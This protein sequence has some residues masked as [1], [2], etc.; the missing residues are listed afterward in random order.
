[1]LLYLIARKRLLLLMVAISTLVGLASAKLNTSSGLHVAVAAT[2]VLVDFPEPSIVERRAL[3][4]HVAGLQL[5][6]EMFGRLMVTT[7]VLESIGRRAGIPGDQIAGVARTTANVPIPLREPGSEVR[8]AQVRD[9]QLPYH[10]ELQSSP[11][12][13]ILSIYAQAPTTDEAKRLADASILG[14]DDYVRGLAR[15]EGFDEA[16]VVRLRQLGDAR[17]GV[18]NPRAT[19]VTGALTFMVAFGLTAAALLGLVYLHRRR[20]A[21]AAP[22]RPGAPDPDG[23][24]DNWPHTTRALPWLLAGFIAM[25][26]LV[27][28]N[29]IELAASMPIDMKLDRLVLP[30]IVG[31]WVLAF[32]AGGRF[33]PR[34]R[35]TWIHVALGAF[36]A[37]A[38]LSVVL[39]AGYLN[40]TLE[41]DLSFKKLPLL[42][43]YLSI[44]LIVA[45]SVRPGE[46]RPFLTFTLILG[47][48]TG[49]GIIWE[50]RFSQNLFSTWSDMALPGA[51]HVEMPDAGV[52]D[53]L[54]RRGIIGPTEVG[55][56]AVSILAMALPIA[57]VG[58]VGA[59]RRNERIL[60]ALAACVLV[61]AMFATGRKS[62]LVAPAA[63][64]LTLAYFRRRELLSMAP[65]GLVVVAVVSVLSPGMVHGIVS[66]FTRSDASSVATTS[67]RTADYDAIRPDVWTH[68]LFGRGYGSYNHETYRILDSEILG[69]LVETG[70][71]GLL[72]F[73]LI[74]LSVVFAAR[75]TIALRDPWASPPA[76]I[77]TAVAV[78]FIV[79]STL[80]D[81]LSFPH[82][83]YVFL[84]MAGL[85]TVV[86]G[87][88]PRKS[89]PRH[90]VG[91][92][93][94]ASASASERSG[95]SAAALSSAS[96]SR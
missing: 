80:Y 22:S 55:L 30:F 14:L 75:R 56:E 77:G 33:A 15:D 21:P 23:E 50:L 11:S 2:H 48:I 76:L 20:R 49:L 6:A 60:Y 52:V 92:E 71:L 53:S 34:L 61:A 68:I 29:K 83:T 66:Q 26:W 91:T 58:I 54:G 96:S 38:F 17:G 37:C 7:P 42:V 64:V 18:I 86:I 89:P 82:A 87:R 90:P 24:S 1:M 72:A 81:V 25:L 31:A 59:G 46:V 35:M 40:Q 3:E 94:W 65:L 44:F 63:V 39:N 67:D 79:V 8:A 27:P 19:L 57:I 12:E 43:S 45:S 13:P 74:G 9:S 78:C 10:L 70:A 36:L 93:E 51:F 16:K 47:V 32:M 4:Q 95:A 28:F 84:Y 69:R 88:Q 5:R 62:A 85:V 73:L 41:F